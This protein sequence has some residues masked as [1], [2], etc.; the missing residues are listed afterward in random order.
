[1]FDLNCQQLRCADGGTIWIARCDDHFQ[2]IVGFGDS[3][4]EAITDFM[5]QANYFL[6]TQPLH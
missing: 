5:A 3:E 6:A 1:M 4:D 2:Q